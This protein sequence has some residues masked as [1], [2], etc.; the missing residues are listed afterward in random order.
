MLPPSSQAMSCRPP[1][2]PTTP[3]PAAVER[4]QAVGHWE[5]DTVM[6]IGIVTLVERATGYLLIGK[7]AARTM[8]EAARST[9]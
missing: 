1:V 8:E 3:R 9:M 6:G 2:N 4:R 7:L 5:I